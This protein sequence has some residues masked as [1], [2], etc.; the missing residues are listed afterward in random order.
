MD[1]NER[2]IGARP[3]GSGQQCFIYIMANAFLK[4]K[5]VNAIHL[6]INSWRVVGERSSTLLRLG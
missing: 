4:P 6:G 2:L 3:V 5:E 1:R